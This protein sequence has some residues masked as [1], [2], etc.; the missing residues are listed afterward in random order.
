ML[1]GVKDAD[2]ADDAVAGLDQVVAAEP[3]QLAKA[4]Q[5]A[6]LDLLDEL[7]DTGL[8]DC[9]VASNGGVHSHASNSLLGR[10]NSVES[11]RCSRPE[12]TPKGA[13]RARRRRRGA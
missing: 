10:S 3:R 2:G 9:L 13:C 1:G 8:V 6:V 5:Q 4:G 7:V 11:F 12:V